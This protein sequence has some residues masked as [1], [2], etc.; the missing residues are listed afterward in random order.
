MTELR[1][2]SDDAGREFIK[3]LHELTGALP[4]SAT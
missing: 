3:S 1:G 2:E 4:G